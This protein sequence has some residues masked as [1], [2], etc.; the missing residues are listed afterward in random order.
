M[1]KPFCISFATAA[2]ATTTLFAVSPAF[3]WGDNGHI[4]VA[5]VAKTL[6]TPVALQKANAILA[7][8]TSG[9]KLR[10]GEAVAASFEN[11]ATWADYYK[12]SKGKDGE[13]YHHTGK[14][15]FADIDIVS[16]DIAAAC[17]GLDTPN[18]DNLPAFDGPDDDCVIEKINQFT[19]ELR[20]DAAA[21]ETLLAL[22]MI[23]HLVG[24]LHQ[25]LHAADD[26]DG[27][28]NGKKITLPGST[29]KIVLHTYW[30]NDAVQAIG[31]TPQAVASAVLKSITPTK[32]A[33]W[34]TGNA[35]DWAKEVHH[36]AVTSAYSR[37]TGFAPHSG[38]QTFV[39]GSEYA[40]NAKA[41]AMQ[42]IGRAG[43]R[44]AKLLNDALGN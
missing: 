36:I 31:S 40:S 23:L 20:G 39:G 8:D 32:R 19:P 4:A 15:H 43:V 3:A 30:D 18:P 12:Y 5:L 17:P 35:K 33:R 41:V 27:G 29:A 2:L 1:K 9:F 14:W 28:G 42:Q 6:L 24:D 13:P 25:P 11:Q 10:T 38:K 37:L 26:L 44:L 22:Q 34:Q 7:H 16:H 21:P